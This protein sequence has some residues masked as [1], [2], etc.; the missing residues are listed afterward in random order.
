M[1]YLKACVLYRPGNS[2]L[3]LAL[4]FLPHKLQLARALVV[5]SVKELRIYVPDTRV[6]WYVNYVV[7]VTLQLSKGHSAARKKRCV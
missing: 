4:S 6:T 7:F 2:S 5:G 3:F 1:I